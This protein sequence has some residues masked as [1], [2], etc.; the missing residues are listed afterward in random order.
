MFLNII[1]I[2]QNILN[3]YRTLHWKYKRVK[4]VGKIFIKISYISLKTFQALFDDINF[5]VI[6]LK[7]NIVFFKYNIFIYIT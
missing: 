2:Q 1:K 3:V 6:F 7:Y 4:I 5:A